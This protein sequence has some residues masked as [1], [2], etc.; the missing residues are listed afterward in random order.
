AINAFPL[1]STP[2]G[3]GVEVG[4]GTQSYFDSVTG[5][6]RSF[7]ARAVFGDVSLAGVTSFAALSAVSGALPAGVA[8]DP[9]VSVFV[10]VLTTAVLGG[11]V[12][13]CVAFPDEDADGVVDGTGIAASQLRLLHAEAVGSAF[14]DV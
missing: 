1:A 4:S 9:A 3:P 10:D 12:R 11:D 2:A 14:A 7:E 13:L 5:T 6:T 8:L